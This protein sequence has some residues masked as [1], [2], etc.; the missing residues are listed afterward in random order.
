M[1]QDLILRVKYEGV[2][3]DLD[4]LDGVPLRVDM[5]TVEAG[6]LGRLFGIGSQTFSLPGTKKNNKFFKNGYDVSATDIPGMYN[7]IDSWVIQNGETLLFGALQLEEIVTSDDGYIDYKVS[8]TDKAIQFKEEIKTKFLYEADWDRYNHLLTSGSI[9]DS[10]NNNLFSGSI[11]YP[12]A[13][14]GRTEDL[15]TN[16]PYPFLQF[17][18][19]PPAIGTSTAPLEQRQF[20]PSVRLK[21][22]VDLI[23]D[24]VG[25]RYTG[26]FMETADFNQL[27]LLTKADD[28][29]GPVVGEA[30]LATFTARAIT[31][32]NVFEN[33]GYFHL[34]ASAVSSD[35]ANGYNT[36][37]SEYSV[38]VDGDYDTFANISFFNPVTAGDP[39]TAVA[40]RLQMRYGQTGSYTTGDTQELILAD[41]DIDGFGPFT[42]SAGDTAKSLTTAD[43]IFAYY[44]YEQVAGPGT[45]AD[46]L[47]I[48]AAT[49]G[50]TSGPVTYEGSEIS[51]SLQIN[52]E[53]RSEDV[54]KGLIQQFNLVFIPD[55]N[56]ESTIIIET[57]D[58]W[59][60]EGAI[61]DWTDKYD[62]S[63]RISI[64]G[65]IQ[66]LPKEV[67]LQ[68]AEDTDRF[69]KVTKEQEPFFQYGTQRLIAE[70]RNAQGDTTIGD[71]FAP[72]VI[73]SVQVDPQ[74]DAEKFNLD[75]NN[76]TVFPHL[77]RYEN[78][79]ILSYAFKPRIGY[80]VQNNLPSGSSIYLGQGSTNTQVTGNYST[81]SNTSALP[82][83]SGSS[84]DLHFNKTY[85]NFGP[86]GILDL[87]DG[88]T[89]Y[90][91]YWETYYQS[92][93]WDEAKLVTLDLQFD[94]YEFREIKL[95]DRILI[96][97]QYYRINKIKGFNISKRDVVTVE[98]IR[99]FPEYFQL[100]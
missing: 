9:L 21:D 89:A 17:R 16:S 2:I 4:V 40:I 54:I 5:S 66:D 64:R 46:P 50:T 6:E 75:T 41:P 35:P 23:F 82:V 67:L 58:D 87:D 53:F 77:Y 72:V 60:R 74:T 47:I 28:E 80:K 31:T 43:N 3:Y 79:K 42:L 52:P 12:L 57:F 97:N 88:I 83:V 93:Y 62:Q 84:N 96:K 65:T 29:F 56:D 49:L 8:I 73:G 68:N 36:A 22:V 25:F 13:D 38:Q 30:S 32:Q 100:T 11:F 48:T 10:W 55:P 76:R 18:G 94:P 91:S 69:S 63:K 90:T 92:L 33:T 45:P 26:S 44:E 59:L 71:V 7:P 24:Q 98:L 85:G 70:S 99:L 27:Y 86:T 14:Y 20:L 39:N 15:Q 37:T 95:N 34:T 1:T 78:D 81:I 61:K 51:M 19:T